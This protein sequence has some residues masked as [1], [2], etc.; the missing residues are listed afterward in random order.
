MEIVPTMKQ[1]KYANKA[2]RFVE[3]P[4]HYE[5]IFTDDFNMP[6]SGDGGMPA[7]TLMTD[8]ITDL[9]AA[10]KSK[11]LHIFV[12]SYGGYVHSLNM[13]IQQIV[14]FKHRVG[15]NLGA[16]CSCGFMLLAYCEELYTSPYATFMYHEMWGVSV[17]KVEEQRN[18][19]QFDARWW[20]LLVKD[21]YINEILTSEEIEQGK[22]TEVW[23][24]GSELIARDQAMDYA[25][26]CTRKIPV[27]SA[28]FY[29]VG[30][31]VYRK[32]GN[33][34]VKYSKDK[35]FKKNNNNTYKYGDLL[36]MLNED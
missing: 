25:L 9:K 22:L 7:N 2:I 34:Y 1:D 10:D 29:I 23:L 14:Q 5:L 17:G 24:T 26:Y 16:A 12:S 3:K 35:P 19:S 15:I 18:K 6:S 36:N 13:L 32:E 8:I 30:E 21:S 28:D 11:E 31:D 4:T 20:E 33:N 27:Q